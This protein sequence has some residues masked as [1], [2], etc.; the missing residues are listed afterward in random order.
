MKNNI[1]IESR[2]HKYAIQQT[3]FLHVFEPGGNRMEF[4]NARA[5]I[6]LA[7]DWKVF[8]WSEADRAK[9]QAWGMKTIST[10]HTHDTP[11]VNDGSA[12]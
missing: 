4:A 7:P 11:P 3:L 6:L 9:G 12:E 2:P 1:H 5:R 10:F 8:E